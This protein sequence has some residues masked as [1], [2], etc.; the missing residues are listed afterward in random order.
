MSFLVA[1]GGL[2]QHHEIAGARGE[3]IGKL[4]TITPHH[5][6]TYLT[7]L[8]RVNPRILEPFYPQ[9]AVPPGGIRNQHPIP[10][11]AAEHNKVI[12]TV[13]IHRH[14]DGGLFDQVLKRQPAVADPLITSL[15]DVALEV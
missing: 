9:G 11:R 6:E 14:Y 12:V 1:V 4:D 3:A 10:A 5:H 8:W 15:I 13:Q 7:D 2:P